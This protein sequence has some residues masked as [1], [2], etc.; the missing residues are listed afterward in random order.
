MS[1]LFHMEASVASH[2]GSREFFV[3]L[4]SAE[5]RAAQSLDAPFAAGIGREAGM[6][7]DERI[8]LFLYGALF[9]T[10]MRAV[11]LGFVGSNLIRHGGLLSLTN[12]AA[13]VA[14]LPVFAGIAINSNAYGME[15]LRNAAFGISRS[16]LALLFAAATLLFLTFYLKA[17]MELSRAVFGMG[18]ATSIVAIAVGRTIFERIVLRNFRQSLINE[19]IIVDDAPFASGDPY[20]LVYQADY[21]GLAPD[22]RNPLMLDKLGRLMHSAD[23]VVVVCSKERREQ[24]TLILQSA[25]VNGEL[26]APEMS[27]IGVT[28]VG[29][30]EGGPTFKV[31]AGALSLHHRIMKRLL[32][33]AITVPVLV[34]LSPVMLLTAIA[35][36]L[37]SPGGV[38]FK[39]ERLG[40]GN[41][42][43][44]VYK[45][46]S[47]RAEIC[48]ENG[49]R[50]T[51][52]DD[53]RITRVGQFIRRTS[54]DELPQL[55]NVLRG[56]M[57]LVGPR[58]H[59]LG[60][61]AGG[62]L[63]WDVD[64]RYWYRHATKP[65]LTG[66]AQVRGYRG[67][68]DHHSDLT[69]RLDSDL[70]YLSGWTLWRDIYIILLTVRVII[71][72]NAY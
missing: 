26:N 47:M 39:Q 48:D 12:L 6:R 72:R 45:F 32:D 65:G 4:Q 3:N 17:S 5:L 70:E 64:L 10:D 13:A 34:A 33:L 57:S 35:I 22:V 43:F 55:W 9:L 38:F 28:E 31:S 24:W 56:E 62:A 7:A 11:S 54:I 20:S 36:R 60:S 67:S 66:L 44:L 27:E 46:R 41:R 40:R 25:G 69:N 71:H 19:I 52:R 63:F 23:R 1:G 29:R 16:V 8:R 14:L 61:R 59:A 58:P 18:V 53:D 68:T 49:D 15:A 2:A 50:S 42:L 51:V 21:L 30:F 37:E